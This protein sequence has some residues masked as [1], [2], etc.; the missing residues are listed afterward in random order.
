MRRVRF[1]SSP[2][3]HQVP[4]L[5]APREQAMTRHTYT[6]QVTWTGNR[7]EGTSGY[8]VYSRVYD[9]ACRSAVPYRQFG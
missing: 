8:K 1:F 7:G 5:M 4:A 9:V 3:Q 2:F 6:A